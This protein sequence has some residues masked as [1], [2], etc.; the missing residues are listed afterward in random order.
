V[1]LREQSSS[2]PLG[3]PPSALLAPLSNQ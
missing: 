1:P 2:S 3:P